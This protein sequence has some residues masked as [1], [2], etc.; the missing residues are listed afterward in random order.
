MRNFLVKTLARHC[1]FVAEAESTAAAEEMLAR[2]HFDV[3][4]LDN[5]MP[6]RSGI[7]WLAERRSGGRLPDTIMVTAYADLETAIAAMR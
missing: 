4:I 1:L 7:D 3:M 2:Q 5:L 6:E